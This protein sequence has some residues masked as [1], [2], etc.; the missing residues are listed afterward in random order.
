MTFD[1]NVYFG[2]PGSMFTLPHPRGGVRSTRVRPAQEFPLGNGEYRARKSLQ[3]SRVYAMDWE[4]LDF[5][6]FS[7]IQAYDQGHMG[8]GPFA[9]LDP[10]QR[11]ML[12]VNQSSS[13]SLTNDT[14]NFT[15]AGS[16]QTIVSSTTLTT[17]VPRSLAWTFNFSSPASAAS[18][19]TLDSPY[20]GWPGVPVVN[21]ALA[22]SFLA[23]GGGTDGVLDLIPELQWYDT[24]GALLSTSTGSTLTTSTGAWG[25]GLVTASPPANFAYVLPRVHYSAGASAG[26]IV[27]LSSF[28]LEEGSTR[29]TWCP[30][31]GV[32]PV[33][34]IGHEEAWPWLYPTE[35]RDRPTLTLRQDGR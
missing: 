1:Q 6:T 9:F 2:Q 21:R 32:S 10:G 4:R 11:N 23:R 12:M 17:G 31:T 27:Y 34:V 15:I 16:G 7:T 14:T 19:L 25:T 18:I 22:F 20:P 28:Q 8:P 13:T 30:G 29:G 5:S 26:S 3:G 24:A 33:V 35:V